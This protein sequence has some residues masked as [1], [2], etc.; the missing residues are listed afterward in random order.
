MSEHYLEKFE[1]ITT[2]LFDVDGVLTDGSVVLVGGGEQAR[3]MYVRD[4]YA[5]QLAVKQ[6]FHIGIIS[7][8]RSEEVRKRMNGLGVQNVHLGVENKLDC[9]ETFK[10]EHNLTDEQ[11]LYVGD[12]LPD[13]QV[14]QACGVSCAP[15]DADHE[16]KEIVDYVS[17][18]DGGRGCVRDIIEK[19]LRVQKKWF[20]RNHEN[21]E[22][23]K[24]FW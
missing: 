18:I 8:G 13:F 9:Y 16:I 23:K 19:V 15:A 20:D 14:L 21:H 22:F 7:G 5:L 3:T 1:K 2:L 10:L 6:G 12:D 11:I 17:P 4:G 24:F